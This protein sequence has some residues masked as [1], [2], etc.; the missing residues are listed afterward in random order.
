MWSQLF[1]FVYE[2]ICIIVDNDQCHCLG[3]GLFCFCF[4]FVYIDLANSTPL[5]MESLSSGII[6]SRAFCSY[7]ESSPRP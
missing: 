6:A 5:L 1:F 7:G 2:Y 3:V 4:C